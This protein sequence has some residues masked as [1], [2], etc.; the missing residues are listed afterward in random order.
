MEMDPTE[1]R[2][3]LP[4]N[5]YHI[6]FSQIQWGRQ[7]IKISLSVFKLSNPSQLQIVCIKCELEY[8]ILE[9]DYV[10]SNKTS[11]ALISL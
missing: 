6:F 3:N 4:E 8:Y 1:F 7:K 2:T 11:I 10:I 5:D 9:E